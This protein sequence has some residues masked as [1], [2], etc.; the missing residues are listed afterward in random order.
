MGATFIV[1]R[2]DDRNG[3]CVSGLD[4]SFREAVSAANASPEDDTINF[5]GVGAPISVNGKVRI[6]LGNQIIIENAGAL[7]ING[8]GAN[9]LTIDGNSINNGFQYGNRIF[10]I[11]NA[12]VTIRNVKLTGGY[13]NGGNGGNGGGILVNEG[14]LV[15]DRVYVTGN[16]T[17][18]SG[19]GIYYSGGTNHRIIKS[20]ISNNVAV[21]SGGGGFALVGGTLSVA[22]TTISGNSASVGS[23]NGMGGGF[24]GSPTLRNVTITMNGGSANNNAFSGNPE[25]KNTIVTGEQRQ[26]NFPFPCAVT[27]ADN[28]LVGDC[29]ATLILGPLQHNGGSTPTFALLPGSP[30]IDGGN[31]AFAVDPFDNSPLL[32]DQ[33][34]KGFPRIVDGNGDG[35]ATVDI[36]AFEAPQ[37]AIIASVKT[38]KK[39]R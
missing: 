32:T 26:L 29:S 3:V 11:N 36:G 9:V 27:T 20:T 13:L 4:C 37:T 12:N 18:I 35:E 16:Q 22:N 21:S 17:G 2:S 31:N 28:N 7:T 6:R 19:G 34:G 10:Y 15:L 1:T 8:L 30:A 38:G 14:T 23:F 5:D 39:L 33:R 25:M 24:L